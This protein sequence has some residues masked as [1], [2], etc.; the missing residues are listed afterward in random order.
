M[1]KHYEPP[2]VRV[3]GSVHELTLRTKAF[4]EPNDGDFFMGRPLHTVS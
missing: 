4:D 2:T 1:K 3:I